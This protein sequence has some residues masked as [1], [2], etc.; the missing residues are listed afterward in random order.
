MTVVQ[1]IFLSDNELTYGVGGNMYMS[2]WNLNIDFFYNETN[3]IGATVILSFSIVFL[4]SKF[5][6]MF[7]YTL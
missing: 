1:V 5:S 7:F 6:L 2:L 3:V 4:P